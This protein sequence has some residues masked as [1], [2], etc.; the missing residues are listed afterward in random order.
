MPTQRRVADARRR[1]LVQVHVVLGRV[2]TAVAKALHEYGDV[3]DDDGVAVQVAGGELALSPLH[4][5]V[6]HHADV[7]TDGRGVRVAELGTEPLLAEERR[8]LLCRLR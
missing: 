4:F 2:D 7:E 6:D 5:T 1:H 3:G 8:A